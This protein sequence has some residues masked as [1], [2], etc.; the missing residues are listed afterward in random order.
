[1][2]PPIAGDV[3]SGAPLDTSRAGPATFTVRAAD[4][5]A[6]EAISVVHYEI[7]PAAALAIAGIG[8]RRATLRPRRRRS[9]WSH[10]Q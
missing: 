3:V 4:D 2:R 6:N 10:L 8:L 9:R 7:R 1:L 5:A